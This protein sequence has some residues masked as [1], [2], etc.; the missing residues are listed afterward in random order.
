MARLAATSFKADWVINSDG[1]EFWWPRGGTLK[2]VLGAV[3]PRFGAVRG[4]WRHFLPRP[5]EGF[6]AERMTARLSGM[7]PRWD[8]M[9]I[10]HFKT[11]H[12]ADPAVSV[13]GG[14]HDALGPGLLPLTGWYPIDVLHFPL[15]SLEQ[16]ERKY[17]QHYE[18]RMGKELDPR[19]AEGYAAYRAGRMREFYEA[20]VIDDEALEQ[21]LRDGTF[22][23]DTRLRDALRSHGKRPPRFDGATIDR[24]YLSEVGALEEQSAL[25]RARRRIE[26]FESRLS[27]LEGRSSASRR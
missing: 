19:V 10:P 21:G 4:M 27:K 1:D 20:D 9:F 6:F 22:G 2:N 26:A 16:C 17:V 7:G 3:P 18:W 15:R 5:G 24:G 13:G 23:I 8:H 12:R 14:N 25:T 11:A